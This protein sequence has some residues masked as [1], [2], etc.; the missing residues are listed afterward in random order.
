MKYL[1]VLCFF[2]GVASMVVGAKSIEESY[3]KNQLGTE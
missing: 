2:C 3:F 1:A